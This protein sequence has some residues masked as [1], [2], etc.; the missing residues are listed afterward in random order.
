MP[1]EQNLIYE[2]SKKIYAKMTGMGYNIT[3][4]NESVWYSKGGEE[5]CIFYAAKVQDLELECPMFCDAG[6][7][8][9]A[10]NEFLGGHQVAINRI[11]KGDKTII[12]QLV[13][14]RPGIYMAGQAPRLNWEID[15]ESRAGTDDEA[16]FGLLLQYLE[17]KIP[18][19]MKGLR[20]LKPSEEKL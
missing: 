8:L 14:G 4:S 1:E 20:L 19:E 13:L 10:F 16:L 2:M 7:C 3:A 18:A 12:W 5:T 11:Q 17:I 15:K 9:R 6:N